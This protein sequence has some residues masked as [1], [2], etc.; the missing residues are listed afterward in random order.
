MHGSVVRPKKPWACA[1]GVSILTGT[2]KHQFSCIHRSMTFYPKFTKFAVEVPAYKGRLDS[3][4]EVNRA[5]RFRDM[6]D[7][8]FSFCSSFFSPPSS[9]HTN[10]KVGFNLQART[11]IS[12]KFGTL[13]GCIQAN[14]GTNFGDNTAYLHG[15]TNVLFAYTKI[16]L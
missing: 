16:K 11:L 15:D 6:R 2:T 13:V 7:Q 4:F 12:L 3:K 9:F 8:S 5:R 14:S 1:T 10:H